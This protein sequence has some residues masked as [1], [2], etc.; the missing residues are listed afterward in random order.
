MEK[1]PELIG[2]KIFKIINLQ[3]WE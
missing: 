1:V 3:S 2:Q